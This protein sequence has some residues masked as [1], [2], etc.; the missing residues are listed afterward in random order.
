MEKEM[1]VWKIIA[2]RCFCINIYKNKI[3]AK[4]KKAEELQIGVN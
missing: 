3:L 1:P 2:Y 4:K